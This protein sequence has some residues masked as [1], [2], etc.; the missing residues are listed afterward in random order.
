MES[1]RAETEVI[2]VCAAVALHAFGNPRCI[3]I[4]IAIILEC[5]RTDACSAPGR[6]PGWC[7]LKLNVCP[8]GVRVA[9]GGWGRMNGHRPRGLAAG[10]RLRG[11]PTPAA[12]P[13]TNI[14][15]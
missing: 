14:H 13:S 9:K 7:S 6:A 11:P 15:P 8:V 1:S 12:L 3:F 4:E 2:R 10:P 5:L